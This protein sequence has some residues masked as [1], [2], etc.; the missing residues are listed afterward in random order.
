MEGLGKELIRESFV[1]GN[2]LTLFEEFSKNQ[3]YQILKFAIDVFKGYFEEIR[4]EHPEW[5]EELKT[6][7]WKETVNKIKGEFDVKMK[8]S[9]T[10][11]EEGLTTFLDNVRDKFIDGINDALCRCGSEECESC[12]RKSIKDV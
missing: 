4:N 9:F 8:R 1:S 2:V 3:N 10:N 6:E 12:F 5:V 11:F 7:Q